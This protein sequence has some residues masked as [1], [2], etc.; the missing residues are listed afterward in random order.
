[1]TIESLNDLMDVIESG[2]EDLVLQCEHVR[3]LSTLGLDERAT[4]GGLWVDTQNEEFIACKAS[5][6]RVLQYYGGFEYID[7]EYRKELGVYVFYLAEPDEEGRVNGCFERMKM[8][9]MTPEERKK[10]EEEKEAREERRYN[11]RHR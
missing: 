4:Y 5:D 6:D 10:Y 7:K 11:W 3:D 8:S 2:A 9:K 1:M